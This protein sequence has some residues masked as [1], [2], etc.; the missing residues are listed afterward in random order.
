MDLHERSAEGGDEGRLLVRGRG[1]GE[2]GEG[3]EYY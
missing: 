2:S 1:E 3:T